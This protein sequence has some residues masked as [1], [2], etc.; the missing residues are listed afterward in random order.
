MIY[1]PQVLSSDSLSGH[2]HVTWTN[3]DHPFRRAISSVAPGFEKHPRL[4]AT[5]SFSK[6]AKPELA[7]MTAP[8]EEIGIEEFFALMRSGA[9]EV[10]L[11]CDDLCSIRKPPEGWE[12]AIIAAMGLECP[13]EYAGDYF[14][15]GARLLVRLKSHWNGLQPL[16][17]RMLEQPNLNHFHVIHAYGVYTDWHLSDELKG[18]VVRAYD[19]VGPFRRACYAVDT[20]VHGLLN[21]CR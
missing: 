1:A 19:R 11:V 10:G 4:P 14:Y 6:S 7:K 21:R 9:D 2:C 13:Q 8:A 20:L 15:W 18:A 3:V 12:P 16:F 17:I 5:S